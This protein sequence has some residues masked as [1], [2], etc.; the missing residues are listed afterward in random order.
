M[1]NG[2][3]CQLATNKEQLSQYWPYNTPHTDKPIGSTSNSRYMY[4]LKKFYS[5][6][7]DMKDTHVH[8]CTHMHALVCTEC[9]HM[10]TLLM[11]RHL[12]DSYVEENHEQQLA[13]LVLWLAL[14]VL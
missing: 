6:A 3:K 12:E 13:I 1:I 2:V 9:I 14:H 10:H 11:Y 5:C 8:T 7:V 4:T